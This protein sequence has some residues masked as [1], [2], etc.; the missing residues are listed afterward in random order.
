LDNIIIFLKKTGNFDF[1]IIN[2]EYI[3]QNKLQHDEPSS[4]ASLLTRERTVGVSF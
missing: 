4:P 2:I 1:H 3:N